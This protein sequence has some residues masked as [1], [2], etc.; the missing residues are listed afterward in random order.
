MLLLIDY[1]K[2]IRIYL[3]VRNNA[4][5]CSNRAP[6]LQISR[7]LREQ[8]QHDMPAANSGHFSLALFNY[9]PYACGEFHLRIRRLLASLCEGNIETK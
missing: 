1:D 4:T 2:L 9:V 7:D 6:R 5:T 3:N 8:F